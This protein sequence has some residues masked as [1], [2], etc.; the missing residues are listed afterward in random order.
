MSINRIPMGIATASPR[1]RVREV[2][3]YH[4]EFFQLFDHIITA[5]EEGVRS[6]PH[7]DIFLISAR[8]FD[9]DPDPN[10]VC[11]NFFI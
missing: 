11:K 10:D 8:R 1:S 6:K 4:A 3:S 5:P 9:D 7:P 2:T